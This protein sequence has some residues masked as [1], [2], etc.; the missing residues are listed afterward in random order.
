MKTNLRKHRLSCVLPPAIVIFLIWSVFRAGLLPTAGA[1]TD[2]PNLLVITIDTLRA[3]HVGAYGY[4]AARTPH[5]DQLAADG[6]LFSRAFS[7]VPLTLP[8][9]LTL[10]TGQLPA[11]HGVRDNGRRFVSGVRTLAEIARDKGYSTAAFVGAFPLDSRFGLDCGFQTYDDL[12]GEGTAVRDMT[13]IERRAEDVNRKAEDWIRA[14]GRN[15]FFV[16]VHYYDPHA[17]YDPP[18]PFAEEFAGREYDGEIA[19]TDFYVGKLLETLE[20]AGLRGNTLI[21]LA[22][23]HGEGLGEHKEK[24]HGIF[25]YDST[26]HVPLIISYPKALP[27]GRVITAPVGLQDV[28]PTVLDLMG[29]P[30]ENGLPGCSLVPAMARPKAARPDPDRAFYIESLAPLL[31]RNWAP[32][33]GI[34]TSDWKYIDAP[35]AELYDLAADPGE[36]V[37]VLDKHADVGRRLRG[38][39]EA[40]IKTQSAAVSDAPAARVDEETRR[41]LMSLG[42]LSGG[43][44]ESK[45]PHPDPKTMIEFDNLFSDAINASESGLL[46]KADALYQEILRLQPEFIIGYEYAAYNFHKMGRGEDAVRLLEGAVAR[47]IA[48][49]SLLARL[50]MYYQEAGRLDESVRTLEKALVLNGNSAETFNYLGV[51]LF[52][53]GRFDEAIEAFK[54]S[55]G[56]DKDYA[57]AMNNLGNCFLA[58]KR[59]KEAA[60]EYK[61]AIASDDG[62]ASAYNGLAGAYYRQGL[63]DEAVKA[64]EKSLDID[65]HRAEALYNLGRAYLRLGRKQDALRL[66]ELFVR[67][68]PPRESAKDIEEVKGVIERLKRELRAS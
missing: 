12:Y 28:L 17:P 27:R 46:E 44:V 50:G 6:V 23:D 37:N 15:P 57:Q 56:L 7:H 13:F 16:W 59:Y 30:E 20:K 53:S 45:S 31:G 43:A 11:V 65:P 14:N 33:R 67:Y 5:L 29:W 47:G 19:Y 4:Q 39:L 40:M 48:N 55:I 2:A 42:Y 26:L 52:K 9:H 18:S 34:R 62:L 64:W 54:K 58:L 49:D 21:V 35:I 41:K 22:S 25:I 51:S 24:T 38:E 68:A 63:V 1:A 32:L 61:A 10:F 66:F 8:S 36:T 60:E 3:D